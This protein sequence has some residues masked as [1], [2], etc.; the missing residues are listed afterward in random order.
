MP[1]RHYNIVKNNIWKIW[2]TD[3]DP[4]YISELHKRTR[5]HHQSLVSSGW[6]ALVDENIFEWRPCTAA[7]GA[8]A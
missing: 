3:G 4:W 5:E 2:K 6:L 7:T 8:C 1:E